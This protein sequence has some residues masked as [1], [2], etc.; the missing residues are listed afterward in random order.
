[1][2]ESIDDVGLVSPKDLRFLP[3]KTPS[4]NLGCDSS[5]TS[6]PSYIQ[7]ADGAEIICKSAAAG[8]FC[9]TEYSDEP[10]FMVN[11]R[12]IFDDAR[13]SQAY[14][15]IL[16]HVEKHLQ[17]LYELT[18]ADIICF[19]ARP[20]SKSITSYVSPGIRGHTEAFYSCGT[21]ESDF[22]DLAATRRGIY[23]VK[24]ARREAAI[25]KMARK[26]DNFLPPSVR[27]QLAR[28][29]VSLD[30]WVAVEV[31]WLRHSQTGDRLQ[32][33]DDL[34]R[35]GLLSNISNAIELAMLRELRDLGLSNIS[36]LIVLIILTYVS[37]R[38]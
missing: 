36:I 24:V 3:A 27:D 15:K 20:E 16:D 34:A 19:A 21:W 6:P 35:L 10:E 31:V 4:S 13:H 33:R 2:S 26:S 23:T 32:I 1:M 38:V 11:E 17:N 8:D 18:N 28:S 14:K 29:G 5:P 9:Q 37:S 22:E 7:V 25:E 30:D 12:F